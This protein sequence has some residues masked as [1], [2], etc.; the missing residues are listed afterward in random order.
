MPS[1][2]LMRT[3]SPCFELTTKKS[4]AIQSENSRGDYPSGNGENSPTSVY[5]PT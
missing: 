5:L 4:Q 3:F 1:R 2:E